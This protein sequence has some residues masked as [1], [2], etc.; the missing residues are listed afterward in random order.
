MNEWIG[1]V[2]LGTMGGALTLNLLEHG[3]SVLAHD[4]NARR[5][6]VLAARAASLPEGSG[7]LQLF[8]S[9][10]ALA[11]ALPRPRLVLL[12]VPPGPSTDTA[13]DELLP[14]LSPGDTV[15]DLGNTSYLDTERR[16]EALALRG[17]ELVGSGLS[18]GEQGARNG[19]SLMPGGTTAGYRQAARVLEPLAARCPDGSPCIA[20]IG[21][22]GAGHFVKM[23][24]NGIEYAEMQ[25]LCELYTFARASFGG[26]MIQTAEL[27]DRLKTGP[28]SS[29]LVSITAD[30][31]REREGTH[32]L[33]DLVAELA[34]Q[35]GTGRQTVEA[36]LQYGVPVPTITAAV[37][38]RNLSAL[39]TRRG[40]F[41][42]P[43]GA[44]A[45][46][47]PEALPV[48]TLER[49]L[50]AARV[51]IYEQGLSLIRTVSESRGWGVNLK[52]VVSVWRRGCIIQSDL[53]EQLASR[54]SAQETPLEH[55]ALCAL[56][57]QGDRELRRL[58][59][60]A[61]AERIYVPALASAVCY[62]DGRRA[63]HLAT[64]LI[65]AQRDYFGAHT[66]GRID[67]PGAFHTEWGK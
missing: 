24:H 32:P 6:S 35:K 56:T 47:R 10:E 58:L 16:Q 37:E 57:E 9:P 64:N 14:Y 67:R 61:S 18:G 29:Y 52:R 41:P 49:A 20:H 51:S 15:V 45:V 63:G 40:R 5:Q 4:K 25:L 2:G 48:E 12:L 23:V 53:L 44:F 22:G 55:P 46:A 30:I 19:P 13:L 50:L 17:I 28:L 62:L 27:F 1:L 34:D 42:L 38:A 33:L 60:A 11:A 7:E 26:D 8:P 54:L 36:A 65:A 39:R 59:A 66:Y 31:L 43:S 21:S 3:Y